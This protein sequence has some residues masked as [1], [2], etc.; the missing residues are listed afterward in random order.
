M[1]VQKIASYLRNTFGPYLDLEE[2]LYVIFVYLLP[3]GVH[4]KGLK[5][6]VVEPIPLVDLLD[7]P[8][9]YAEQLLIMNKN[10]NV[11]YS[12]LPHYKD[13]FEKLRAENPR[14]R[15]DK[16]TAHNLAKRVE[17]DI[18]LEKIED[19]IDHGDK[20]IHDLNKVK[21][22]AKSLWYSKLKPALENLGV[23]P[24]WVFYTGAGL[25]LVFEF[26]EFVDA[27]KLIKE[28]GKEELRK[29][30]IEVIGEDAKVDPPK[31]GVDSAV[32]DLA[33]IMRLPWTE[34]LSY[35]TPDK[36]KRFK[37]P[38]EELH[39]SDVV[40]N[41]EEVR[42]KVRNW[43][44]DRGLLE[45]KPKHV[46]KEDDIWFEEE[47]EEELRAEFFG[48]KFA[49]I[50]KSHWRSGQ[51]HALALSFAAFLKE[52]GIPYED[53]K[54]I[55]ARVMDLMISERL[56]DSKEV[57]SDR[58]RA[59][60]DT[61]K[62]QDV[63][64]GGPL[65]EQAGWPSQKIVSL[66]KQL[67]RVW[68]VNKKYKPINFT[69][70][71]KMVGKLYE[72][73]GRYTVFFKGINDP[74]EF[75][76]SK[77]IDRSATK[78]GVSYEKFVNKDFVVR[79][80]AFFTQ[81]NYALIWPKREVVTQKGTIYEII[82]N[83]AVLGIMFNL[84]KR[85]HHL[86]STREF[87]SVSAARLIVKAL[88]LAEDVTQGNKPLTANSF[89]YEVL[90]ENGERLVRIYVPAPLLLEAA[91]RLKIL[92]P[93]DMQAP[94]KL[95]QLLLKAKSIRLGRKKK[96]GPNN[97]HQFY[98]YVIDGNA[99]EE[100]R[101]VNIEEIAKRVSVKAEESFEAIFNFNLG[102]ALDLD[103]KTLHDVI[104]TT[105]KE[106]NYM[107]GGSGA[108]Y[109]EVIK[110]LTEKGISKQKIEEAI[111]TMLMDGYLYMPKDGF[112]KIMG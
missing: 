72:D 80:E 24:T 70:I 65:K 12:I 94:Q 36:S 88:E 13:K 60:E 30:L 33:R 63:S 91:Y 41:F 28:F 83:E 37:I 64:F 68:A 17:V 93:S 75:D 21:I 78:Y 95:G 9:H 55:F 44:K 27:K 76:G 10:Y 84:M 106:L 97:K 49:E 7:D 96:V 109:E 67:E 43:L 16:T 35:T 45:E 2:D 92:K 86:A 62:R 103:P 29:L 31:I 66:K 5:R 46:L 38:V 58:W 26:S 104:I 73:N 82:D 22:A 15:G 87:E 32:F 51:R 77:L 53:A 42:E 112:L 102:E 47:P 4:R 48:K 98:Y 54:A 11:Y 1:K 19:L 90:N 85:A 6:T 20:I 108:P 61:Y 79:L 110:V 18:D 3:K 50:L 111:K 8:E 57:A 34:N 81:H 14:T 25:K 107:Y 56:D 52:K 71:P 69:A 40:L 59:F 105:V 74:F 99:I 100:L 39:H 101:G 89:A 23:T